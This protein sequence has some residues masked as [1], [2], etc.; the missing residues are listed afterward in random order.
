MAGPLGF[1]KGLGARVLY[2]MPATAICWST[3]EFFKYIL[4]TQ[5]RED[6]RSTVS[7]SS[8]SNQGNPNN[9][10]RNNSNESVR[11]THVNDPNMTKSTTIIG[12]SYMLPKRNVV[13]A[14]RIVDDL[15]AAISLK[16]TGT[17]ESS[18]NTTTTLLPP[19]RELPSISGAGVYSSLNYNTMHH[20]TDHGLYDL[21]KGCET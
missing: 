21:R 6:Y 8:I 17:G 20:Q 18:T 16:S 1:F 9:S 2:S 19:A 10:L 7:I 15:P 13:T 14:E 12:M 4:S 3:Y 5:S 11:S